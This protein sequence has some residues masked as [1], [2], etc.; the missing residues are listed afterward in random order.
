MEKII[1][2]IIFV[3]TFGKMQAQTQWNI[4]PT[5]NDTI[6]THYNYTLSIL[7]TL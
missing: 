1:T 2:I 7:L 5:A 6:S 3:L 4:V